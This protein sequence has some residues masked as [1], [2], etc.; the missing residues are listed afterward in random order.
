MKDVP[1]CPAE[2]SLLIDFG[3]SR[4]GIFV[5]VQLVLN[6]AEHGEKI[7]S[8]SDTTC[9]FVKISYGKPATTKCGWD[10]SLAHCMISCLHVDEMISYMSSSRA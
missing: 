10:H 1:E 2:S 9:P 5:D 8:D 7:E 3:K 4:L 6:E